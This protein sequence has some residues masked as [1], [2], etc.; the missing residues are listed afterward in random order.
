MATAEELAWVSLVRSGVEA[1]E[2]RRLAGLPAL[3]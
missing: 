3:R 2:A 1:A